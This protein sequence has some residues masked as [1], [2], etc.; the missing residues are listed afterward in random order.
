MI[1]LF[2][3]LFFFS[4]FLS[5]FTASLPAERTLRMNSLMSVKRRNDYTKEKNC[6]FNLD[7]NK[8]ES[9]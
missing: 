4:F 6:C 7:F 1:F 9:N 5:F 2:L 3:S 8:H